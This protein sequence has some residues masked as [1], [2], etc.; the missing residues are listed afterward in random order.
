VLKS[1]EIMKGIKCVV[2]G[3]KCKKVSCKKQ[4]CSSKTMELSYTGQSTYV[5]HAGTVM[6]LGE[7]AIS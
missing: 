6:L 5:Y 7:K 1:D 2:T 4:Q 3:C